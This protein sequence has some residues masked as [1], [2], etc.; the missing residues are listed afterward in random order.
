M[1]DESMSSDAES[2]PSLNISS[3]G[4]SQHGLEEE[5]DKDDPFWEFINE[6]KYPQKERENEED[7]EPVDEGEDKERYNEEE[8][9]ENKD[10]EF[11]YDGDD[12][13]D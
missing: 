12:D 4:S 7:S 13:G 1:I 2:A 11:A 8:D 9:G 6:P 5:L 10:D 3:E